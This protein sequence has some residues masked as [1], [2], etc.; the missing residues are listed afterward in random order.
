M[1][2]HWLKIY[3]QKKSKIWTVEFSRNAIFMLK[4]RRVIVTDDD[5]IISHR[6]VSVIFKDAL[7]GQNDKELLDFLADAHWNKMAG[8][9]S[10]LRMYKG[11][12]EKENFQFTGLSY[13]GLTTGIF[14]DDIKFIFDVGNVRHFHVS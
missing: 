2:N 14:V 9:F 11:L 4:P 3:E 8:Y 12:D 6:R 7:F 10:T 5:K 13:I 1:K